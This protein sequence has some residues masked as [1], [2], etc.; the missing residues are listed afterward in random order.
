VLPERVKAFGKVRASDCKLAPAVPNGIRFVLET[1]RGLIVCG[2]GL[3]IAF[4]FI[5]TTVAP[6]RA[7][8]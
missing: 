8:D 7:M 6:E 5:L 1:N 2:V 4:I 3:A